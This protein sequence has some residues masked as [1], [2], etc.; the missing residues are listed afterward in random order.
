MEEKKLTLIEQWRELSTGSD[1]DAT[2]RAFW[3][4]YFDKE[5]EA[6]RRILSDVSVRYSGKAGE[7]AASFDM[8]EAIFGGFLD[9]INTSLKNELDVGSVCADTEITLDIDFEK[10]YFNM[11]EAKAD[12]LYGLSEW[13]AVLSAEK[14]KEITKAWRASKQFVNA[15]DKVGPNDSCPCGSGKKDNKCCGR[16]AD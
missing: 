16:S 12:W 1:D 5:T 10:L 11:H 14:R 6:Y 2:V 15:S 4:S 13:D 3:K 9:G 8:S 7:L